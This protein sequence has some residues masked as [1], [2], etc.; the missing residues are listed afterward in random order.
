ML[1]DTRLV[2]DL[3]R[4]N[5]IAQRFSTSLNLDDI[6]RLATDGL[7]KQFN[8]AFARIWLVEPDRKLLRLA[9][10]SGLYTHTDGSFSRIPMGE[11]KIGRI[12]QNRISLL[13][14]N[15][16]EESWV[17]YPEWAIANKITSFAGYP[18]AS[19]DQ[20][21]GVLAV[22]GHY[23]M[24]SEFLEV[25]L[26]F[27]TTLTVALEMALLHQKERQENKPK[28]TL[29]QLSL[30]E[31]L[32]YI[33]GQTKLTVLGTERSLNV[34]QAQLF[35]NV[36]EILNPLD[37]S[38]CRLTYA[39]DAV[40]LEAIA[41]LQSIVPQEQQAWESVAFGDLSSIAACFGGRLNINTETSIRAMQISL[42][43]SSLDKLSEVSL[44]VQ[45]RSSLL[46]T[47]F[48]QL[49]Y[50]AGLRVQASGERHVPLLTDQPAL[51]ETCDRTIWLN[52]NSHRAPNGVKAQVNLSTTATQLRAAVAAVMRGE[53]WGLNPQ[54]RQQLSQREQE[55]ISLLVKGLR[56]REVAE[57]LHISDSTVKFHINNI[58]A[59]LKAK[60]RLQA[61]YQLMSTDSLNY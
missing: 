4:A 6:A 17:K 12:A 61:L 21:I 51:V 5:Q 37:C 38:Y 32:A 10:S 46:Q 40:S 25:L 31:S 14:N 8:C 42:T 15:L 47:G 26:G 35:L 20:V 41:A 59:K 29:A 56:D 28:S 27:C 1:D 57:Q 36:A 45:C 39:A 7:V 16:A 52:H 34:S 50:A 53:E 33:L 55:V 2:W 58:L 54:P 22:F 9:A 18:L 23:P 13:S 19:S 48:T 49:A 30:S 43:F 11:F 60:T 3:Q 24:R 44:R